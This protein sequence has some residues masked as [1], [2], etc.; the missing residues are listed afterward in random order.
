MPNLRHGMVKMFERIE[1]QIASKGAAQ[2]E[3]E[4][5]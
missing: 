1:R 3:G 4:T 2:E 5:G